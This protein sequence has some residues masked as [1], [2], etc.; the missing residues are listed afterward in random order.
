MMPRVLAAIVLAAASLWF[1]PDLFDF[2]GL[3]E[4]RLVGAVCLTVLVL[5]ALET[6]F[7]RFTPL[8]TGRKSL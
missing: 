1:L 7:H 5:T 3:S 2:L 4:F 6:A 8:E